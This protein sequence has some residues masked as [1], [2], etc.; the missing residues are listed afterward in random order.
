MSG[1]VVISEMHGEEDLYELSFHGCAED[2][3]FSDQT[4]ELSDVDAH[5]I[6][7]DVAQSTGAI[8]CWEGYKPAWA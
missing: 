6:A 1:K 7:L 4:D 8:I 2:Y 3:G 5:E